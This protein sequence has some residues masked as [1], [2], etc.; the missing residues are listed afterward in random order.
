MPYN[1]TIQYGTYM[2]SKEYDKIIYSVIHNE[3]RVKK[4][5]N[6]SDDERS[7][8]IN[9]YIGALH[10]RFSDEGKDAIFKDIEGSI[11]ARKE[12]EGL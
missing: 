1:P 2:T 7:K 9:G 10:V 3:K 11:I 8:L 5:I 4:H 6:A 12:K